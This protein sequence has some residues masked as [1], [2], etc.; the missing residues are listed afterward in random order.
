MGHQPKDSGLN[1]CTARIERWYERICELD[2]GERHG[3]SI[4]MDA[5]EFVV[6]FM[7]CYH[8]KDCIIKETDI[9]SNEVETFIT[10]TPSLALC[11]DIANGTKH[12]G[13]DEGRSFRSRNDLRMR[14][15]VRLEGDK[16]RPGLLITK[17]DGT[18]LHAIDLARECM[19]KWVEF[20]TSHPQKEV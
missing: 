2:S 10:Q 5:D 13:I 14:P 20:L 18:Q 4:E 7:F 6:F 9:P 8:L 1:F 12:F 11:A 16:V 3:T 19:E 17:N 15:C